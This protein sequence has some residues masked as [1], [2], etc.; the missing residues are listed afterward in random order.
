MCVTLRA[1]I[2]RHTRFAERADGGAVDAHRGVCLGRDAM[3]RKRRDG[4]M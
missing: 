1:S 3:R 4:A 2:G